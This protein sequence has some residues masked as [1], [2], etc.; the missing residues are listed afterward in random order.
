M[1]ESIPN[2]W[3]HTSRKVGVRL[4]GAIDRS[5]RECVEECIRRCIGERISGCV[6]GV[7]GMSEGGFT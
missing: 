5:I 3:V 2:I 4:E 6:G 1:R 7:L